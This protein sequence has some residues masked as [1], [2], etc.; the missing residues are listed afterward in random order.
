[1]ARRS[2]V[3]VVGLLLPRD[4]FINSVKYVYSIEKFR[5]TV[6]RFNEDLP[7]VSIFSLPGMPTW[8]ETQ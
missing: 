1:V 5:F 6:G 3:V 2:R 8:L 4:K 7:S